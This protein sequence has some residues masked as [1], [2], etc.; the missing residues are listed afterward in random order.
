MGVDPRLVVFLGCL[1][2]MLAAG[3]VYAFG[4]YAQDLKNSLSLTQQDVQTVASIGNVGLYCGIIAGVT[5]DKFG[6]RKTAI[7]GTVIASVG[8][9]L[10]WLR[11]QQAASLAS[12]TIDLSLYFAIAWN[13]GAFLDCAAVTTAG[14]LFPASRGLSVG[15]I[16]SFFGLSSSVLSQFYLAFFDSKATPSSSPSSNTSAVACPGGEPPPSTNSSFLTTR[17]LFADDV[18]AR[19]SSYSVP[20]LFLLCIYTLVIGAVAAMTLTEKYN[21]STIRAPQLQ[22]LNKAYLCVG[23]LAAYLAVS[24]ALEHTFPASAA[25]NV[26]TFCGMLM[27]LMP[28]VACFVVATKPD[29]GEGE[30]N[31]NNNN[32]NSSNHNNNDPDVVA[33]ITAGGDSAESK[34]GRVREWTT[35]ATITSLDFYL[36]WL[37]HFCGTANG[38]FFLNNV[39]QIE[40]SMGGT[41]ASSALYVSIAGVFNAFGRMAAGYFSDRY[42]S[43]ISR[44][45]FFTISLATMSIGQVSMVLFPGTTFLYVAGAIIGFTY[46]TFWA[47]IPPMTIE[48]FGEKHVGLNYQLLGL[49]PAAGSVLANVVLASNVYQAHA[50]AGS[51]LCCGTSCFETTHIV[52]SG[53]ALVGIVSSLC[54]HLRTRSFYQSQHRGRGGDYAEL[55]IADGDA[56]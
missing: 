17:G 19:A 3:S 28:L 7:I 53:V 34:S 55:D 35:C 48:L 25:L 22:R 23:S 12:P 2:T 9:L 21:D 8:Y 40:Q 29:A 10:A 37:A 38:L 39:A 36:L 11:T 33:D 18:G 56:E 54:V 46:G 16:K 49:A 52:L 27:V 47:L 6:S 4:I 43:K 30:A 42:A 5:Y 44:P 1:T 41:K 32:N 24:A 50:I 14:K 26:G 45:L 20:F 13:G 51:T 31:I 15:I